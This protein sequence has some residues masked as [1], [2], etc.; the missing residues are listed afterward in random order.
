MP[1]PNKKGQEEYVDDEKKRVLADL[2]IAHIITQYLS[3][4]ITIP[5][6]QEIL[7]FLRSQMPQVL[8]DNFRALN[9]SFKSSTEML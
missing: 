7:Q 5:G 6:I 2:E 3:K 9:Y 1:K 8:G 4:M